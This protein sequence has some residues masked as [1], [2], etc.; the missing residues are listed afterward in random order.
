[1]KARNAKTF[2]LYIYPYVFSAFVV[3]L[4]FKVD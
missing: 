2:K 4:R 3:F 1:M